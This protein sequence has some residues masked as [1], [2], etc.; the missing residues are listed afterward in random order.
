MFNNQQLFHIKSTEYNK[1]IQ[2]ALMYTYQNLN[3]NKDFKRKNKNKKIKI[4]NE[5][6]NVVDD[7]YLYDYIDYFADTTAKKYLKDRL[8]WEVKNMVDIAEFI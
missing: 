8:K 3:K 6:K 1:D 7:I 4:I 2:D 5:L